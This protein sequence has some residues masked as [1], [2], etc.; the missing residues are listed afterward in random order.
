MEGLKCCV[1]VLE[2]PS[3]EM[4]VLKSAAQHMQVRVY[5]VGVCESKET[6]KSRAAAAVVESTVVCA[7]V[8]VF[9]GTTEQS[10]KTCRK[11]KREATI[12]GRRCWDVWML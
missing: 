6:N 11:M 5:C 1:Y 3:V 8:C 7:C 2:L 9:V 12:G 4:S 10:R